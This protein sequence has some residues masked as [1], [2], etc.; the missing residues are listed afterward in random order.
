MLDG[1][2]KRGGARANAGR[3]PKPKGPAIE[4]KSYAQGLLD[5]LNRPAE[6]ADPFHVV[7]WRE[8]TEA[9]GDARIRLDAR[10]RVED[11]ALGKAVH[12]VNHLHDKPIEMNVNLSIADVVRKVRERKE[13]YERSR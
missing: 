2:S 13:Q 1:V 8:L 11:R 7:K 12:T 6:P 9:P 5:A 10:S 4:S 3:K